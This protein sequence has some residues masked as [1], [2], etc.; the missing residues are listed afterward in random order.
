MMTDA[1]PEVK[2]KLPAKSSNSRVVRHLA[3]TLK[4]PLFLLIIGATITSLLVPYLN[5]KVNRNRMLQEAR[6]KKALEIVNRNTEFNIKLNALKTM[7]ESFH[8]QNV[9]LQL[10]PSE[11][12]EAQLKF[13]DDF[14]KRYLELDESAWW[15]HSNIARE[16][17][18]LALIPT[19][20]LPV[21]DSELKEYAANVSR[22]VGSLRPFW[23]KLTSSDY[24]PNDEKSREEVKKILADAGKEGYLFGE[25]NSIIEK[26]TRHYTS[27]H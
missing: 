1:E 14:N 10:Q 3:R 6:Q 7:M 18:I 15:W 20:A 5:S 9:R 22:S 8:N 26:I 12:R 19:D 25:R 21:L 23:Q 27:L 4:H 11:L 24:N 17:S 2:S 16:S 13:R